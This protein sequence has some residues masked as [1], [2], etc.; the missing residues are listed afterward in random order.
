MMSNFRKILFPYLPPQRQR[1]ELRAILAATAV[2]LLLGGIIALVIV[3]RGRIG[4]I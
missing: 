2:G 4:G 3:A 1:R